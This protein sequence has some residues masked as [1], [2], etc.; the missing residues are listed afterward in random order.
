MDLSSGCQFA[1]LEL[2]KKAPFLRLCSFQAL[3]LLAGLLSLPFGSNVQGV[4]LKCPPSGTNIACVNVPGMPGEMGWCVNTNTDDAGNRIETW[5]LKEGNGHHGPDFG[6]L[7]RPATGT[8]LWVGACLFPGGINSPNANFS[9][10]SG[11]PAGQP[12]GKPDQFTAVTWH[13]VENFVDNQTNRP[14]S[15]TND[16]D[17]F[18]DPATGKLIIGKSLGHWTDYGQG[19][20]WERT[21]VVYETNNAPG[22][23]KG[24]KFG[25]NQ[26]TLA[27]GE[28]GRALGAFGAALT[29]LTSGR[30]EYALRANTFEPTDDDTNRYSLVTALVTPSDR[31]TIGAVDIHAPFVGGSAG[32][33]QFGAWTV[34]QWDST[35]VSF[36]P[37]VTAEW[38]RGAAVTGFGFYSRGSA[39]EVSWNLASQS[40]ELCSADTVTGPVLNLG[41]LR[42][43]QHLILLWQV[44]DAKLQ[45]ADDITGQWAVVPSAQSGYN[46][47]MTNQMS[48]FRLIL[49]P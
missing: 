37:T 24:L 43:G 8:P 34:A 47:S 42:S 41:F 22:E 21:N 2:A 39:G 23:F 30:W 33:P 12:N 1:K 32:L 15:G 25:T 45:R 6:I 9:D 38:P 28:N 27:L 5:C 36:Q 14:A 7:W 17:F 44:P 35:F 16:W 10:E 26:I 3:A 4:T 18:F 20:E 31:F 40:E 48:F 19:L 11:G 46:I 29:N 49:Q 13:N